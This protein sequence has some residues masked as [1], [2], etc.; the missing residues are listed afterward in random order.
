MEGIIAIPSGAT[1][2]GCSARCPGYAQPLGQR[3]WGP[4][5][6][7]RGRGRRAARRVAGEG[8]EPGELGGYRTV[9]VVYRRRATRSAPGCR[10]RGVD[11]RGPTGVRRVEAVL[12]PPQLVAGRGP[13]RVTLESRIALVTG[14]SSGLGRAMVAALAWGGARVAFTYRSNAAG[15][16]AVAAELPP[17]AEGVG[18]QGDVGVEADVARIVAA[19]V[20]RF[21]GLDILVNNAGI[22]RDA[23]LLRM[24]PEDWQTVLDTNLTG[25]VRCCR[26][27][28]PHLMASKAGRIIN[29]ASI[30]GIVGSAGQVNYSAAKAGRSGLTEVLARELAPSGI[31]V[32][33]VAPGVIDAGIVAGMPEQVRRGLVE[34][35]PMGRMGTA[36][37]VAALVVFLA[38]REAGYITGQTIAVDGG[39]TTGGLTMP[40]APAPGSA[41]GRA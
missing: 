12:C 30:A 15:A 9:L 34:V 13:P 25:A 19:V 29:I 26:Q 18:P 6:A 40:G 16:Q 11:V 31:T 2:C 39:T 28:L 21:G 7:A 38:S 1:D 23:L 14:G 33:A 3:R 35:V 8:I 24:R 20:A 17:P 37:E 5:P 32:N 41:R 22:T 10:R 27:A 36:E 4:G